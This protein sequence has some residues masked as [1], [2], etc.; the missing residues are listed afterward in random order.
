MEKDVTK[1]I[2]PI[3]ENMKRLIHYKRGGENVLRED[4]DFVMD[5]RLNIGPNRVEYS[6]SKSE[7]KDKEGILF[8]KAYL[9]NFSNLF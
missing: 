2:V 5:R 7:V 4:P 9:P 3:L 8:Y 1:N 6:D